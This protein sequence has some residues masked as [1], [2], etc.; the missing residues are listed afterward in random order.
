M[1]FNA[2]ELL[3]QYPQG[4]IYVDPEMNAPYY[5]TVH[6]PAEHALMTTAYVQ[7]G[8]NAISSTSEHVERSLEFLELVNNDTQLAT[9]IRFGVEGEGWTDEDNDGVFEDGP[10]NADTTNRN[11]YNWYGW[12]FGSIVVSKFPKGY[13]AN[14]GEL[15]KELNDNSNQDTNLGFIFDPTSVETEIAACNNVIDEYYLTLQKGQIDDID[16][17]IDAFI[18]KLKDN[19]SDKVIEEAQKQLS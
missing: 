7:S 9:T 2:G 19:G 17:Q 13:P 3:G 5:T 16:A 15:V 14:F 8:A 1:L 10:K 12:Q 11:W 18:Q 6:Y 4:Y